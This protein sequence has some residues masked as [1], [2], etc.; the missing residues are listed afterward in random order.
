MYQ[1]FD[2]TSTFTIDLEVERSF[3]PLNFIFKL[4]KY[5]FVSCSLEVRECKPDGQEDIPITVYFDLVSQRIN[6]NTRVLTRKIY[7][8]YIKLKNTSFVLFH[9]F[10]YSLDKGW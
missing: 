2:L 7:T 10:L 6:K 3:S 1:L 9:Y 4:I 5:S 8:M